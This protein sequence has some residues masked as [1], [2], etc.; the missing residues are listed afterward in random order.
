M[1]TI[2]VMFLIRMNPETLKATKAGT[3]LFFWAFAKDYNGEK[4]CVGQ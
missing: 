4:S 3:K 1:D 2:D